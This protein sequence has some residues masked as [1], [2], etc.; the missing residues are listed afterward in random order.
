MTTNVDNKKDI[1][2]N[3]YSPILLW[4]F[5]LLLL[6]IGWYFFVSIDRR[7]DEQE[8]I[9]IANKET[10]ALASKSDF[11]YCFASIS[12]RFCE[13]LKSDT[14]LF[15]E[16]S[17]ESILVTYIKNRADNIFKSPF[18]EHNLIVFR[19]DTKGEHQPKIIFSNEQEI[20]KNDDWAYVFEYLVKTNLG[21]SSYR[22]EKKAKGRELS[23][24]VFGESLDP[25]IFAE[26]QRSK[27]TLAF[28]KNKSSRFLW[29]YFKDNNTEDIFGFF[30]FVD[31]SLNIDSAGRHL[32]LNE[33]RDSQEP[34]TKQK[35]GAFIPLFPD[36]GGVIAS[37]E[38]TKIPDFDFMLEKWTPKNIKEI[39]S[40]Q[41]N[42]APAK[43]ED[44]IIGNL[45]AFFY[46][47]PNQSHASVL[48]VPVLEK[49]EMPLW[50][51]IVDII[52]LSLIIIALLR[53]FIFNKWP[54]V[55]LKVRFFTSYFLA[56]CLPLG[57]MIIAS[58][59]YISEY[60]HTDIFKNQSKLKLC[61]NQFDTLKSQNQE[62]YKNAF[63]EIFN[64]PS[65]DL[66][67]K[68]LDQI[69]GKH[70]ENI[71]AESIDVLSKILNIIN[72]NERDL[73]V[74]NF[75]IIDEQGNCLSNFGNE[76]NPYYKTFNK[77]EFFLQGKKYDT[78][79]IN[80]T[81]LEQE[82]VF[83]TL[84]QSLRKRIEKESPDK[85]R[86]SGD[87]ILNNKES[88]FAKDNYENHV[89]DIITKEFGKN[90][91]SFIYNYINIDNVPRYVV[92]LYWDESAKDEKT[93]I[94]SLRHFALS[95]P[96][97]T[98]SAYKA[99]SNGIKVWPDNNDRHRNDFEALS[100][101]LIK[102][103]YF[104]K[105]IASNRNK[106]M[107]MVAVPSKKYKDVI[108][109]GG[110]Y[111]HDLEMDIFTRFWVIVT[112]IVIAMFI[113]LACIH[114]S[115]IIF[116]RPI[117]KLKS[118]LDKISEGNF[119]IQIKSSSQ[120]EFGLVCNE[121][122]Q[123]TKELLE[124]KKL[125]T[126]I[127][128]H[129]VEALSRKESDE[130]IDEV[131]SFKGTVL[132]SDIRNFTGMC[133]Q[134]SPSSITELLDKHFA[135]MTQ[136][137]SSNGG[138]IYK[139]IGDAIEV[140]FA[141]RDDTEVTSAERAFKTAC[142]MLD[143][144]T[145]INKERIDKGLFDYKIGIGLSYGKMHAGTI[146]SI[147]SRLDYAIIGDSLKDASKLESLSRNNS[148]FPIIVDKSFVDIFSANNTVIKFE[149][150]DSSNKFEAYKV[151]RESLDKLKNKEGKKNSEKIE[152][153]ELFDN[154][155]EEIKEKPISVFEVEESFPFYRKFIP[156][157]IFVVILAVIMASGIYFV[158]TSAHYSE[159]I[160]LAT[161]NSRALEQMLCDG[162]G[163]TAF[164]IKCRDISLS[165]SQ[166]IKSVNTSDESI[167][168]YINELIKSDKSLD[169]INT[170]SIFVKVDS[171]VDLNTKDKAFAD[172]IALK[173]INNNGFSQKDIE[174]ICNSFKS[175][176]SL[177]C[178][179]S[180]CKNSGLNEADSEAFKASCKEYIKEKYNNSSV[181]VFG[182]NVNIGVFKDMAK[183]ASTDGFYEGKE[184]YLFWLDFYKNDSDVPFGILLLTMPSEQ[185]KN[186]IPLLLN[187]YSK[188]EGLIAL[189][190]RDT[191]E[192][193]FSDN[194]P[195]NIKKGVL[196]SDKNQTIT[197]ENDIKFVGNEFLF[198]ILG[199]TN[200]GVKEINGVYYD[201]Y[202]TRLC[203]LNKGNPRNAL[204]WVFLIIVGVAV[205]LW[206]VSTGT[207]R[208]NTSI[209]AK[210]W[211]TLLI[212]AVI[213]VITV[214][215]VFGLF[216]SGYYSVKNSIKK[217]EIQRY[218]ELF[219]QKYE[220]SSPLIWNYVINKNKSEELRNYTNVINDDTLPESKRL[221]T[222]DNMKATVNNWI[223][224]QKNLYNREGSLINYTIDNVFICGKKGWELSVGSNN[225]FNSLLDEL[226]N[227]LLKK[228]NNSDLNKTVSEQLLNKDGSIGLADIKSIYGDDKY[229]GFVHGINKPIY[230][231]SDGVCYGF[232]ISKILS[233][234]N[235]DNLIVWIVKFD[236]YDYLVRLSKE[237]D[238]EYAVN[239]SEKDK[240]G[241]IFKGKDNE[242]RI[243]LSGYSNWISTSNIPL[244]ESFKYNNRNWYIIEG[245]T[246]LQ[247]QNSIILLVYPE[248]S[249]LFEIMFLTMCFYI[250]LGFSILIMIRNTRNIAND[251]I[252]PINSLMEGIKRVNI[253]DFSYRINSDRTDEL[254]ALCLSFDKMI[255][256]LD[257]KRM[258]SHMLSNTARTVTLKEE[259]LSV[260]K[261]EAVL[262]YIGVPDFSALRNEMDAKF[263][264]QKLKI[265][266]S[267]IAKNIMEA[268]GEVDKI[269]GERLLA[270]FSV[271]DNKADIALAACNVAKKILEQEK[272]KEIPFPVAIGINFGEVINGFLGLGNK[273]DFTVIGDAVNITAR[274][275]DLSEKQD[276]NT[277]LIS[278]TLYSL[279][280]DSIKADYY[281]E[282]E[283]KG[284]SQP[285]KVY[286][287]L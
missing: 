283:L 18:P 251:I 273:R 185:V 36:Y 12:G 124:R 177:S 162:Y 193:R 188:N 259:N 201:L 22:D 100:K 27:A 120:D 192:W 117:R 31:N 148:E 147:E 52:T 271:K 205:T 267:N 160:A 155:S 209:A 186:S 87:D 254:G 16:P 249:V 129:A 158:Y 149:K 279:I 39:Y 78:D 107:S 196:D 269:I 265:Q 69:Y 258:I 94:S 219:E 281:D 132:V 10:E 245:R 211:V 159:K 19:I 156:G 261:S 204:I 172:K 256:G 157:L 45:Q 26:G 179:D 61:I 272:A 163:K 142:E 20:N 166:Q 262:L 62:E 13:T 222:L 232:F 286:K 135:Y 200:K 15:G 242:W 70:A 122:N 250:L 43:L 126:L 151:L 28:Y 58:Y 228:E 24:S 103:S 197:D 240:Y 263:V 278:E 44:S 110:V 104:R 277:C 115:S 67:F 46:I 6:N 33:L 276:K 40:W 198:D 79:L 14:E 224:E 121:F 244:S 59:G 77:K 141:D 38:L 143:C 99:N 114:Y 248:Y 51:I 102:Q 97:F 137:I 152:K 255:K 264:F 178:L 243:I 199:V 131:E 235:S 32:A 214:F 167:S 130:D 21:D 275:E 64:N 75:S 227:I 96:F 125:S 225:K 95:D 195:E 139:Y 274:I 241:E 215:F 86:W 47:A 140:V 247:H 56:A 111:Y 169:G 164:D 257:E 53:G 42:G 231:E 153:K 226:S 89:N 221:E 84:L 106:N 253:E 165:L 175:S 41:M 180:I 98:I 184:C 3:K 217:A 23:K 194:F 168:N 187:V 2:Q 50:L 161:S 202:F 183:N 108:F 260:G 268:G 82:E 208:I 90:T 144:L 133:E 34:N 81:E 154:N 91:Y 74:L 85:K 71:P 210:L 229:I 83:L 285:M 246:F 37:K 48:F 11:S 189:K 270:V 63:L 127:S 230:I 66:S 134:H 234:I 223:S 72:K 218:I 112:V 49:I 80:K 119:D 30:V 212:V 116:I 136:I 282:V 170:K 105:A 207:S 213:P 182:Q 118:L 181:D 190:N 280:K 93:F 17:K 65:I 55:S 76:L 266:I 8:R 233:D 109:V 5:P 123:M 239:I 176:I 92:Y 206:R 1:K 7:W 57:L 88:S 54:I 287:L 138:R 236:D 150:F 284:K 216:R 171:W 252:N 35:Y 191:K 113:F 146:G 238:S 220:F 203:K 101:D 173:A 145:E 4:L 25:S 174:N 60:K 68:K 128:D 29:D 73:P 9:D 237:L